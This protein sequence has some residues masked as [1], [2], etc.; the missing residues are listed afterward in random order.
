MALVVFDIDGTLT[1]STGVDDECFVR[2]M[3]E[4]VGL[5]GFDCDWG[6]YPHATD[7]GLTQEIVRRHGGREVT[8]GEQARVQR[9]MVELLREV[10]EREPGRF[11]MVAG[12]QELMRRLADRRGWG[13]SI[14][15]GAW[16]ASA[17]IKLRTAGL[18][19]SGYAAAYADDG[20]SRQEITLT[21]IGRAL[22]V[23][24]GRG[25]LQSA[26]ERWGA[27]VYVGDGVWDARTSRELGIG[28]VGVR[29]EGDF[30]RLR[31]EGA[32]RLLRDYEDVDGAVA[33]IQRAAEDGW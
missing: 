13:V 24:S 19:A 9:R 22:G 23:A 20:V 11:A 32:G 17:T 31:A 33:M 21:S 16:K 6:N 28:F 3:R 8:A 26:R 15:T 1:R 14:A 18:D 25:A 30:E 10:A 7:S 27:V 2:A 12:A 5:S 29:V 4:V